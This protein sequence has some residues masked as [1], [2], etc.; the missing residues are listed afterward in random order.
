MYGLLQNCCDGM[1]LVGNISWTL[2]YRNALFSLYLVLYRESHWDS[3]LLSIV[4]HDISQFTNSSLWFIKSKWD[5]HLYVNSKGCSNNITADIMVRSV[6]LWPMCD[7]SLGII[8]I[9]PVLEM[10]STY[11][12]LKQHSTRELSTEENKNLWHY[13]PFLSCRDVSCNLSIALQL[14]FFL[15]KVR[16]ANNKWH[17]NSPRG[18]SASCQREMQYRVWRSQC[19]RGLCEPYLTV[20]VC[21]RNNTAGLKTY[22]CARLS[23][24]TGK[25]IRTCVCVHLWNLMCGWDLLTL[26]HSYYI[27]LNCYITPSER[28]WG[29]HSPAAQVILTWCILIACW[30]RCGSVSELCYSVVAP[31]MK[32]AHCAV[33]FTNPGVPAILG[34]IV[35]QTD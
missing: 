27:L 15:L 7:L 26:T 12:K 24:C 28:R 14:L 6:N 23:A 19:A 20:C 16:N 34:A 4:C 2:S 5:I 11:Q 17:L 32:T 18:S 10:M 8:C 35:Y 30:Q 9:L 31:N 21:A 13:I 33:L 3:C 22:T 1:V 29:K 25:Q